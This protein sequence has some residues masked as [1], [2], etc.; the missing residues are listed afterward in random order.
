MRLHYKVREGDQT[1]QFVYLMN[2]YLYVCKYFK[3]PVGHPIIM[4]VRS[5]VTE[6]WIE[7]MLR[8]T[9][10]EALPTGVNFRCNGRLLFCL[11]KSCATEH[12]ADGECAH[13]TVA[14][15]ALNGT[16]VIDEDRLAVQKSYVAIEMFEV[17]EY[18]VKLYDPRTGQVGL[19]VECIYI[20]IF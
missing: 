18:G 4:W 13:E 14:E 8:P 19:F 9:T 12:N 1:V 6:R 16:W 5:H 3:F 17:Q 15:R 11:C 10:P 2:L 7:K 20:Y